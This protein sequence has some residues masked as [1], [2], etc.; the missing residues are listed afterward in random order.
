M[1]S[2][3]G[4]AISPETRISLDTESPPLSPQDVLREPEPETAYDVDDDHPV[5]SADIGPDHSPYVARE[6]THCTG[7]ELQLAQNRA[8]RDWRGP[9]HPEYAT[10]ARRLRS[11]LHNSR[12]HTEGKPS[13]DS[14]AEA[15]FF[16]DGE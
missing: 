11:F 16:F 12:W 10:S 8:I 6:R 1:A 9:S 13:P 5:R 14:L 15:G 3:G 4:S 2:G 7:L